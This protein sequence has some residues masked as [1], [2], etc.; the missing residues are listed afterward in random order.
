MF[1]GNFCHFCCQGKGVGRVIEKRIGSDFNLME[2]NIREF[3]IQT[4]R[5]GITYE[6]NLMSPV[7]EFHSQFRGYNAA[8]SVCWI[9]GNS[10]LHIPPSISHIFESLMI[11][12]RPDISPVNYQSNALLTRVHCSLRYTFREPVAGLA[13]SGRPT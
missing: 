2:L 3:R 9:A 12:E 10:N 4:H 6:M 11:I 1:F 5:G 8:P 7:C 13:L